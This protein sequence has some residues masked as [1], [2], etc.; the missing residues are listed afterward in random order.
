M[1]SRPWVRPQEVRDYSQNPVVQ[2]RTDKR[3][4]VDIAR[5]EMYII[6]YCKHAFD[7][8]TKWPHV[9]ES[10]K[11]A[12]ILT[13]EF[14]ASKAEAESGGASLFKSESNDDYSYTTQDTQSA[15]DNLTIGPLLDPYI[16]HTARYSIKMDAHKW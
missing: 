10:V 15:L 6:A 2:N 7:D 14:Y 13:A 9:P 16:Q 4:E 3:L 1:A 12:V 11:T 8:E 5:A